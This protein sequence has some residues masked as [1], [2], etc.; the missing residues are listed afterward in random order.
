MY[1][2]GNRLCCN[3]GDTERMQLLVSAFDD[4]MTLQRIGHETLIGSQ[5]R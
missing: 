3:S 4:L 5:L 2:V 1:R